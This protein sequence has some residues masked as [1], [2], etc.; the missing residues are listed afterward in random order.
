VWHKVTTCEV[1]FE[2]N[3]TVMFACTHAHKPKTCTTA[4]QL[5]VIPQGSPVNSW[6]FVFA[7][8]GAAVLQW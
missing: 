5:G 1:N 8:V 7:G 2:L 6:V 4:F 3:Q